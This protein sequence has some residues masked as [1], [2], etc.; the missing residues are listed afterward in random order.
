MDIMCGVISVMVVAVSRV[1]LAGNSLRMNLDH[2]L[3]QGRLRL[4]LLLT[5]RTFPLHTPHLRRRFIPR[6]FLVAVCPRDMSSVT[7]VRG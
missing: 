4:E 5:E 7:F 2:V 6:A 1:G 3:A